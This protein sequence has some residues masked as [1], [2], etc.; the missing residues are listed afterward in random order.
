MA[1]IRRPFVV[2]LTGGIGSG[3]SAAAAFFAHQGVTVADA[4]LAARAVV[5]PGQ[6]SLTA[7]SERYGKVVLQG[8][9]TLNRRALREII[10]SDPTEKA[11]L[12]SQL[13][14]AIRTQLIQELHAASSDYCLLVSPLLLETDQHTLTNRILVVD[15]PEEDQIY[16]A[17]LRDTASREQIQTIIASQI[18][19]QE[20]LARADDI[21]H[22]HGSLEELQAQVQTL[23]ATY[24]SL[25]KHTAL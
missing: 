5:E 20:R 11:W 9:G 6:P 17:M 12:E 18:N 13:H 1:T 25:A 7:I 24:T 2:G 23:H 10:F 8:D 3:K 16:R 15:C 19:R 22:N 14:P 21:L 4:D